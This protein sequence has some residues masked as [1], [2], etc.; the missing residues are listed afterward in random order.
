[1]DGGSVAEDEIDVE[2]VR[3]VDDKGAWARVGLFTC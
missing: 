1:V 2:D 3:D